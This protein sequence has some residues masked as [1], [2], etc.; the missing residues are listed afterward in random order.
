VRPESRP[1]GDLFE[2]NR[3]PIYDQKEESPKGATYALETAPFTPEQIMKLDPA[4][5]SP[6]TAYVLN[7][8]QT[9]HAAVHHPTDQHHA[10]RGTGARLLQTPLGKL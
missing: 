1:K 10:C 3:R 4:L 8:A 6:Q 9:T 7:L 5:V 2:T